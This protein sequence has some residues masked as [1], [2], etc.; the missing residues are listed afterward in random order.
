MPALCAA[1]CCRTYS[2]ILCSTVIGTEGY[3][4]SSSVSAAAVALLSTSGCRGFSE[5]PEP[6]ASL[7]PVTGVAGGLALERLWTASCQAS[8]A[9]RVGCWILVCSYQDS[10][11]SSGL[12]GVTTSTMDGMFFPFNT[13]LCV[14]IMASQPSCSQLTFSPRTTAIAIACCRSSDRHSNA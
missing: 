7:S 6:D 11:V 2:L 3:C 5:D 8:S 14:S 10:S 4:Q 13:D 9:L 12:G 1:P